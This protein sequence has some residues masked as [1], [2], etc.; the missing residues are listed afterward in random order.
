[1]INSASAS[2]MFM[3]FPDYISRGIKLKRYVYEESLFDDEPDALDGIV[4]C[5]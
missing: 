3:P 5:L 1:M 2:A 4:L